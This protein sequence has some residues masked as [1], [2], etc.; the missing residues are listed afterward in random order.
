MSVIIITIACGCGGE[1]LCGSRSQPSSVLL[2]LLLCMCG[3]LWELVLKESNRALWL[4]QF[5]VRRWCFGFL[6]KKAKQC[7]VSSS[8]CCWRTIIDSV[9]VVLVSFAVFCSGEYYHREG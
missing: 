7:Y 3:L 2:L 8:T 6:K 4:L 1:W 5:G 9:L